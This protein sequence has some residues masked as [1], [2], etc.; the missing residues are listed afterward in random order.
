MTAQAGF[1]GFYKPEFG[2]P[3]H[4]NV[5]NSGTAVEGELRIEL[6]STAIGDRVVYTSP[7]SL[8][9]QSNK[10]VTLYVNPIGFTNAITVELVDERGRVVARPPPAP[11]ANWQ[12][13]ICCM[14]L[15]ARNRANW[16]FWKMSP[17][18]GAMR[19]SPSSI[20]PICPMCPPPG[21]GW[22]CWY[23]ND[24]DTGQFTAAQLD[25]L[26]T[27]VSTGGQL[28]VT[29]GP[30]WQK[31]AAALADWLPVTISGSE[32][33][34][35]LPALSQE[36]GEPFRDPGPYLV[37]PAACAGANCSSIK[38][39]CPCWPP[40]DWDEARLLSGAGSQTGP[41]AGLGWQRAALG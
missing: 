15:S 34:D 2:M 41:A 21:T 39:A 7:I 9:T 12:T 25:A 6:G 8:P 13:M 27:W 1:D 37:T 18:A 4:V 16:N 33:M 30:G 36:T 19:P 32:S 11:S 40:T 24:V 10:R 23:L 3:V 17:P 29:G 22:M 31:T 38:M 28:V 14:A 35:D 26:R 20:W 5:A